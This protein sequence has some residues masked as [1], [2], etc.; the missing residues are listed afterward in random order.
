MRAEIKK[1]WVET[2]RSGDYAQGTGRLRVISDRS[3]VQYCC[4]GVLCE[5]HRLYADK[6]DGPGLWRRDGR[7]YMY[8]NSFVLLPDEV[9]KWA[10][11]KYQSPFVKVSERLGRC[12]MALSELNDMGT[13]FDRIA[14]LIDASL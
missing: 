10:G 1:L 4:L 9:I 5:L 8:L 6:S 3:E 2:L 13:S 7:D 14:D 12:E 11:L